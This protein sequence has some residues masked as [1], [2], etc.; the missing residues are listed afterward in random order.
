M[1]NTAAAPNTTGFSTNAYNL[2]NNTP[3][4]FGP[5]AF[6][7]TNAPK[8]DIPVIPGQMPNAFPVDNTGN[9]RFSLGKA[10][11]QYPFSN[12][13]PFPTPIYPNYGSFGLK[14]F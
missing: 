14:P 11:G 10:F 2:Q 3:L 9:L 12:T 6:S 4:V 5:E 13:N 8:L 7:P 1:I